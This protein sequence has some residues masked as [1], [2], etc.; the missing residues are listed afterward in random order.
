MSWRSVERSPFRLW[1]DREPRSW[2][3]GER[4]CI[5]LA[6][7]GLAWPGRGTE[8]VPFPSDSPEDAEVVLL[9]PVPPALA[10]ARDELAREIERAGG[11][12]LVQRSA[13]EPRPARGID[14]LDLTSELLRESTLEGETSRGSAAGPLWIVVPLL[15]GL[16]DGEEAGS[17]IDRLAALAPEVVLGVEPALVPADRRRIVDC[18][19]EGSFE[20]VFHG[21]AIREADFAAAVAARGIAPLP[22]LP[23]LPDLP[24][25]RARDRRL[26]A[27]LQEAGDLWLRLGRSEGIGESLLAASRRLA[28]ESRDVTALAREGNLGLLSWL[29]P[30]AREVITEQSGAGSD[31]L[32]ELRRAWSGGSAG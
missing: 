21:R 24:A 7:Q 19:G 6:A 23:E 16:L 29:S 20:A 1:A 26:A 28:A 11:C 22:P 5:D 30:T 27:A 32:R 4:V 17:L 10:A 14:V 9:P 13:G 12:A 8:K 15:P 18:L 31:L 25:R 3:G 2:P